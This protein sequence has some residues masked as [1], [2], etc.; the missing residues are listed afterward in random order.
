MATN[1]V[2][3]DTSGFLAL[4]DSGDEHHR[5]AV[6]LQQELNARKRA[7]VTTDYIVDETATLLMVRH[8]RAAALDFLETIDQSNAV[9]LEWIGPDRF[10]EAA[11]LFSRHGDK[12]CH[13]LI[14][15]ASC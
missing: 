1:D 6:R 13:S 11:S 15:L 9:R 12:E 5:A 4:W 2:L 7:F 10:H 8:S 14:A 3:V